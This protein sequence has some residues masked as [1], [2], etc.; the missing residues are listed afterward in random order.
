MFGVF[1]VQSPCRAEF[2]A[3]AS[4][5]SQ[6][7]ELPTNIVLSKESI[8]R[9]SGTEK[10]ATRGVK[11]S[12][13]AVFDSSCLFLFLVQSPMGL[14]LLRKLLCPR[15]VNSTLSFP[16]H[17]ARRPVSQEELRWTRKYQFRRMFVPKKG[18]K[19]IDETQRFLFIFI[20]KVSEFGE[21]P[22]VGAVPP[23]L[24]KRSGGQLTTHA[25]IL[26]S[27]L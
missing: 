21:G 18:R 25:Q 10:Q 26:Y 5:R 12:T 2:V 4:T 1:P 23:P 24:L 9:P 14:S 13:R 17:L 6:H 27:L 20:S 22:L 15:Q 11:P 19:G 8:A 3:R 7:S 16:A